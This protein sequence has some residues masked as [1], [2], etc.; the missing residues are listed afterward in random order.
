MAAHQHFHKYTRVVAASRDGSLIRRSALFAGLQEG[1]THTGESDEL[2]VG[3]LLG[4]GLYPMKVTW[5]NLRGSGGWDPGRTSRKA[6]NRGLYCEPNP[7][8]FCFP[9][10][11]ETSPPSLVRSRLYT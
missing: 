1:A 5:P 6:V 3:I 2:E 9:D 11:H 7:C 4:T 8:L 10:L